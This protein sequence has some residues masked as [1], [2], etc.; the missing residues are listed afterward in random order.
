MKKNISILV[1]LVALVFA[2]WI[3]YE[4]NA[5]PLV[6]SPVSEEIPTENGNPGS[7]VAQ[8]TEGCFVGGCSSQ[9]CSDQ[10][11]VASTCEFREE[12]AC[13]QSAKCERQPSGQCGWTI[14]PELSMCL[15]EAQ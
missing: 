5:L 10:E 4:S 15:S 13:Y 8:P 6:S 3:L 14:T 1:I 11:G 9:I 7:V 12:Y 2:G